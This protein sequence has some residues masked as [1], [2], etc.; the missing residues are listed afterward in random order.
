MTGNFAGIGE[1]GRHGGLMIT[2]WGVVNG[3]IE[4]VMFPEFLA[5]QPP[6]LHVRVAIER[7]YPGLPRMVSNVELVLRDGPRAL[8]N[9]AAAT[10][11]RRAELR[12][13]LFPCER[14]GLAWRGERHGDQGAGSHVD[15]H[16]LGRDPDARGGT[17]IHSFHEFGH[18]RR[19]A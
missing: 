10:L 1:N 19:R 5:Q 15:H 16:D 14:G 8:N 11:V 3:R 12:L 17:D 7:N 13:N 6:R 9:D 4:C 18:R 2:P